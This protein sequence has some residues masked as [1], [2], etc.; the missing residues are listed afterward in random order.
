MKSAVF[1]YEVKTWLKSPMFYILVLSFFL[2]AL[3]SMLG[4]GG[5]FDGPVNSGGSIQVINSAY[6]IS[7][8]GFLFT[9]FMLFVVAIFGGF[10]LYKDYKENVHA[11]LYSFPISKSAYLSGKLGSVI[12]VLLLFSLLTFSG[13]YFGEI[14][15]GEANPK[16]AAKP[17]SSYLLA[18][19]FYLFPN[20]VIVGVTVFVVVGI[21][22]N[23]FS[24]FIAVIC[25]VLFQLILENVFFGHREWLALLDPFGQNAF[26]F[27][28]KE[29]D[30]KM[31][32]STRLP[33]NSLVI[34]N[35]ILWIFLAFSA[36]YFFYRKFNLQYGPF[37]QFKG[38]T[39]QEK[40]INI[41]SAHK[42]LGPNHAIRYH[43][44]WKARITTLG[45]LIIFDFK[46]IVKSWTFL[47]LC[48]FGGIT[49]FFIQ[50]KVSKTGEFNLWPLTR[51]FIGAPLSFYAVIIIFGT[52]LFSGIL[53]RR[54]GQYKM[55]LMLDA[56]T[57]TN[58]QLMLSKIGAISLLHIVQLLLF[59]LIGLAIQIINGY[60]NFELGL[61]NFH[62]FVLLFPILLVW[63][64]TSHFIHSLFPNLFLGLF[65]LISIWMG[66]QSFEQLGIETNILKFA[67]L[68]SLTYSDFNGYGNQ[69]NGYFLLLF[70]WLLFALILV[71]ANSVIWLR[72]SLTSIEERYILTKSRMTKPLSLTLILLSV[73]FIWLGFEIYKLE[74]FDRNTI[75]EKE[76]QKTVLTGYKK[77]WGRFKDITQPTITDVYL[78]LDLY[79]HENR[80][81]AK[82][83]YNLVNQTN[84]KIDTIFIRAGFDEITEIDWQGLASLV[85]E[86]NTMKSYLLK[87]NQPLKPRDS[88]EVSFRIKN[89]PNG[90]FTKNSNVIENGSYIQQDIL[91][92]LGYQFT[93]HELPLTDTLVSSHNY[94]HR[95]A[96]YANIHTLISTS[97]G[98]IA[99]APGYLISERKDGN[100]S[101]FEYRSPRSVK[102]NFS[103]HSAAYEVLEEN[104]GNVTLKL[105]YQKG[106]GFNNEL[107]IKGLKASLDY[108]SKLFGEYP[109]K[110]IRI[111]E[112]PHT[113]KSFSATLKS[114]N[115][116]ASEILFNIKS[117]TFNEKINLPFYT[118]AHELTHEWFGNQVMP[119]DA[120][121]AK[122]LTESITEYI[123][124]R[125]YENQFGE[126]A[127]RKFLNVQYRRYKEGR[128][129]ENREEP[130]LSKVLSHQEYIAYGKG[131]IAFYEIS[132]SIG[133]GKFESV[134]RDYIS[135]FRYESETYPTTKEFIELLKNK[136]TKEEH[137]IIENW[138]S[139]TSAINLDYKKTY[140]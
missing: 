18:F 17:I 60:H 81:K 111:I 59:M 30:L 75:T 13:I 12:L 126:A 104:F 40:K 99:L 136:T 105:Y 128:K 127:A 57:I 110:Q 2:F 19:G 106:H 125:I 46:S 76:N 91:P 27:A 32:N 94:F 139:Q 107:M 3:V 66:T 123:T 42:V 73:N 103:F 121:G 112:F 124:L 20:L 113:E 79:P 97:D 101:I 47:V 89:K 83:T 129:K 122:M 90:I 23:L 39:L 140:P 54:A 56:T 78:H 41:P 24:G 26:H 68:P 1:L 135:K 43:F 5:Y 37:L 115:I 70:Y 4:T 58:L 86:D 80:F 65:V 71:F 53:M 35:R 114:N 74:N 116:P 31:Q 131:A 130:P 96:S 44:S 138:L 137:L 95:D 11:L 33:I 29:W 69:L 62:L 117:E 10:S 7:S 38:A 98:Q 109:Y 100:R 132:K 45:Q 120:E 49:V 64:I 82:A 28:T 25:F 16:I 77:E 118:M 72:G 87:L 8:M 14:I 22:R 108:N 55:N 84:K 52:F 51:L 134:L 85:K 34:W 63:N 50:L 6:S 61:I 102:F 88:L 67:T 21:S 48:L 36:Y 133:K 92:R 93:E 119:A 9:K 15:L